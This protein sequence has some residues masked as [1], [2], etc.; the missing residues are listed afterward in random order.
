MRPDK[1]KPTP[2]PV[3]Q[4]TKISATLIDFGKPLIDQLPPDAPKVL[5]EQLIGFIV[6]TWNAHVLAL[7]AWGQPKHL[8]DMRQALARGWAQHAVDPQAIASFE[9]LNNRRRLRRFA[10]DPRAIGEWGVRQLGPTQWNV[11]CD[12]RLPPQRAS[13]ESDKPATA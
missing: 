13:T 8:A 7:P 4:D 1:A 2:K 5:R 6:G 12:A 10:D 9:M 3:W 11:Y